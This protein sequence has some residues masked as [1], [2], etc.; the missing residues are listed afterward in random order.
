MATSLASTALRR[1]QAMRSL[2]KAG[3]SAVR[4]AI[5][6]NIKSSDQHGDASSSASA[7]AGASADSRADAR[8]ASS[9]STAFSIHGDGPSSSRSAWTYAH[10]AAPEAMSSVRM[11]KRR[12][13]SYSSASSAPPAAAIAAAAAI[14]P[15]HAVQDAP[16]SE[17]ARGSIQA[18]QRRP[19]QSKRAVRS[20]KPKQNVLHV[21]SPLS[22]LLPTTAEDL[23]PVDI[24]GLLT[25]ILSFVK[26][27][28][29]QLATANR[30]QSRVLRAHT[31]SMPRI[32]GRQKKAMLLNR[33][34]R[35]KHPSQ[36]L[37]EDIIQQLLLRFAYLLTCI[38]DDR[39][40]RAASILLRHAGNRSKLWPQ[41]SSSDTRLS[42]PHSW[43]NAK[44]GTLR[45]KGRDARTPVH[46]FE[47]WQRRRRRLRRLLRLVPER[48]YSPEFIALLSRTL[49]GT[50]DT[51]WQDVPAGDTTL[52]P[53]HSLGELDPVERARTGRT[54]PRQHSNRLPAADPS[55]WL[56]ERL[57]QQCLAYLRILASHTAAS[58]RSSFPDQS[59]WL[60]IPE[61]AIA[62]QVAVRRRNPAFSAE[63]I[64]QLDAVLRGDMDF[65]SHAEGAMV[66]AN[67]ERKSPTRTYSSVKSVHLRTLLLRV[68]PKRR[69]KLLE[70]F[71]A[72]SRLKRVLASTPPPRTIDQER[73]IRTSRG[74]RLEQ[75]LDSSRASVLADRVSASSPAGQGH[76]R[77][78][79]SVIQLHSALFE[80]MNT[81]ARKEMEAHRGH[82]SE[83]G[84]PLSQVVAK[85]LFLR[86]LNLQ[87][88]ADARASANTGLSQ[89]QKAAQLPQG[90]NAQAAE[91]NTA[92]PIVLSDAVI[93][94]GTEMLARD[95]KV[96]V[97]AV[98]ACF[99]V[100]AYGRDLYSGRAG[101]ESA[102]VLG[103]IDASHLPTAYGL[104]IRGLALRGHFEASDALFRAFVRRSTTMGHV[105]S[106]L[107][108]DSLIL[109]FR[110]AS[111]VRR[112]QNLSSAATQDERQS[113]AIDA[114][115]VAVEARS[116]LGGMLGFVGVQDADFFTFA[117]P[118][119]LVALP[120]QGKDAV[121]PS[122]KLL[123]S[124]VF[125][126]SK[127]W[128][129][130]W[131]AVGTWLALERRWPKIA[132]EKGFLQAL[133][134]SARAIK[135][136]GQK[137][138][139][140]SAWTGD[141]PAI[142]ARALFR[143][144]LFRAHPELHPAA[145]SSPV[146]PVW[147][148]VG[149][150]DK[151]DPRSESGRYTML[152]KEAKRA[153][154]RAQTAGPSSIL[155]PATT[156]V[157]RRPSINFDAEVFHTYAQLLSSIL[158][159]PKPK[160]KKG[161][162]HAASPDAG[163]DPLLSRGPSVTE[164]ILVLSWMRRLGIQPDQ[165]T[166]CLVGVHLYRYYKWYGRPWPKGKRYFRSEDRSTDRRKHFEGMGPLN[167]W[168]SE[169]VEDRWP[170][171][172]EVHE[173][174]RYMKEK[175]KSPPVVWDF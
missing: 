61:L 82:R 85:K 129:A 110:W 164:L 37:F 114:A 59:A 12:R 148:P 117:Q 63:L 60:G 73:P 101:E 10:S 31:S 47:Q 74:Q 52:A 120:L 1:P 6:S 90:S 91:R 50:S 132:H 19:T 15:S 13:L 5:C 46:L 160:R 138:S 22:A 72:S 79:D 143:H 153:Q 121:R 157:E 77:H 26:E 124:I 145:S 154:A 86:L 65:G 51:A 137:L 150:V 174:S 142:M 136:G 75:L 118:L 78:L 80:Q 147:L 68:S 70:T 133:L 134:L 144:W 56:N 127:H 45:M 175:R 115:A 165:H 16:E 33:F 103:T 35:P 171:E 30:S 8:A 34:A 28:E 69:K 125:S 97:E 48:I 166:L 152:R 44:G 55:H 38:P 151:T 123:T 9:S 102:A 43:T 95:S 169:W 23:S 109:N 2:V 42:L 40:R 53:D 20:H 27:L 17:T 76:P 64:E 49:L 161:D 83:A 112:V 25:Q 57:V 126:L 116:A 167:D 29:L 41:L 21:T 168:L 24:P 108:F 7:S 54:G 67:V 39:A 106:S 36:E 163:S 98:L 84:Q 99:R 162:L 14:S 89:P 58:G 96:P 135:T 170:T 140:Q 122:V 113:H 107:K 71:P 128:T 100:D 155:P 149:D 87:K 105:Y 81:T 4:C 141:D 88:A 32:H 146:A 172:L 158:A 131:A 93:A 173:Y 119:N 62:M 111:E 92:K 104:A 11:G 130:R 94:A 159:A 139:S 18:A 3:S 156:S 66:Q